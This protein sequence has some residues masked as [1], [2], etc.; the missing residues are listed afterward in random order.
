MGLDDDYNLA[1]LKNKDNFE[2]HLKNILRSRYKIDNEYI[3]RKIKISFETVEDKDICVVEVE[4]GDKPIFTQD[5]EK[6]FIRDGNG[7]LELK[8]SETHKYIESRF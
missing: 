7:T 5:D 2:I 6:F 8:P 3:A 4:N 1:N